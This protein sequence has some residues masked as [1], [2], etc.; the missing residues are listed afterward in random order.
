MVGL[1]FPLQVFQSFQWFQS[2]HLFV[3]AKYPTPGILAGFWASV[4][5]K[6]L[7]KLVASSQTKIFPLIVFA[8]LLSLTPDGVFFANSPWGFDRSDSID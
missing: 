5:E 7:N 4:G 2:F 8:P 6:D 3:A 1:L